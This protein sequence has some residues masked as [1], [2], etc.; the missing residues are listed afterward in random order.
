[1][2]T[3]LIVTK[4][5]SADG[6]M[7]VAHSDDDELSDQRLIFVPAADHEPGSMRKIYGEHY[8]YPRIVTNDRGPGYEPRRDPSTHKKQKLTEP[9]GVIPQVKHTF[10]YFDGNYGIMNEHNLM[11][12][13]CTNGAK[14]QPE[15]VTA[16]QAEKEAARMRI[17]YASEIS[18]IAL[19]RAKTAEKAIRI[20]GD[21]IEEYGYYGPGET[22]LVADENHAWVF[23]MCAL[24]D[25]IYHSAWVAQ[26]V[27]DGTVFAAANQFRIRK[28]DPSDKDR[29]RVSKLLE[30]GLEKVEWW[31]PNDGAVDWLRAVSDGEYNHPYYSLRRVWRVFDR[32]NPN[33]GLSPWVKDGYTTDYDF[34]IAPKRKLHVQDV[35]SLYRDHYE[36]TQFDLTRGIAAGPYGDPHR[37]VGLYDG[38]QN[39][40]TEQKVFYGAWER[41][42]S[43]FYQGYT[44]VNQVRVDRPGL[45]IPKQTKGVLWF[46]PD[47]AYTTCFVP[48][49]TS[50]TDLPK[51]YQQGD[52]QVFDP[53]I[54]W[55]V[56]DF[57]A[58]WS[59]LNFQRMCQVDILPRQAESEDA[60]IQRLQALDDEIRRGKKPNI[61][62]F[63]QDIAEDVVGGWWDFA[64]ELIAKY[65]DGYINLPNQ[66]AP[67]D[68]GY[69]STW[70]IHTDYSKG[71]TTYDMRPN[72]LRADA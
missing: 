53:K 47:V 45:P 21:L 49:P 4:G 5:A 3:T 30:E 36:G 34:S 29:F 42:I 56:F 22:L 28:I 41:S 20:M 65:S 55:W 48:F 64:K 68:I 46:G 39:N 14:F 50:V 66:E 2:C 58:S 71:P 67:V 69:P 13:E 35:F 10:A 24:P 19:E 38:A 12:G 15:F 63:C 40:I 27:P 31:D 18:R 23:E 9:I 43:V 33:L 26:Q 59:R 25:D 61:D 44:F 17:M 57:I 32:V 52:P 54:A 6:S 60:L 72:D 70:L 7:M 62:K 16:K 8:R 51:A 1:M 11:M 37:F